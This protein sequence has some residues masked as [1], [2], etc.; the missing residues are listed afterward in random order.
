MDILQIHDYIS[1]DSP[2]AGGKWGR[3]IKRQIGSLEKFPMRCPVIP[4]SAELGNEYRHLIY[5]NYRTLF[6]VIGSRGVI[7]RV[8]H[9]ARLLDI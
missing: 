8:I 1:R 5:G 6:K 3:E 4:E 2:S 7:M 9:G